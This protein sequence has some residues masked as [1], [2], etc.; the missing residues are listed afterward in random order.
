MIFMI[1]ST[2]LVVELGIVMLVLLGWQFAVA[3]FVGGPVMIVLLALVG[4]TVFSAPLVL[5]ARARLRDRSDDVGDEEMA[6]SPDHSPRTLTGWSNASSYALAD[7]TMLRTRT[8]HWL[9]GGGLPRGDGAHLV[10]GRRV[11]ARPRRL[12]HSRECL[13]G[14]T[15]RRRQLG[16]LGGQ[17]A[18]RR[19]PMARRHL[20]RRGDRLRLRRPHRDAAHSHLP[21]VLRARTDHSLVLTFYAV[22]VVAGLV[23]EGLFQRSSEP[24]RP[25]GSCTWALNGHRGITRRILN[26][27]LPSLLALVVWSL[28][29]RR[30]RLGEA[31]GYA[32]DPVCRMQVRIA[33]APARVTIEGQTFY[34]CADRCRERFLAARD[35]DALPPATPSTAP[36][37][38]VTAITL[39]P[40]HEV[41][42]STTTVAVDYI[43]PICGMHVS[44]ESAAAQRRVGDEDIYFCA[45]GCATRFDEQRA[46]DYIDPICGMHVSPESA[47]AQR[48]VDD[49]DIYFCAVGCA[50]RF[51]E[52]RHTL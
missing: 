10:V 30:H 13:G 18:P 28:A 35:N 38:P 21:Q 37:S 4:T 1:S 20:L 32:I 52:Q 26:I 7:A 44:P 3:E 51:D 15:D 41:T 23:T 16:L 2:N 31:S 40:R 29:R 42:A 22:M 36:E 33:D 9:P 49:E 25:V 50:T 43:D 47:A 39:R 48:R 5:A 45:V 19:R 27:V 12:D 24:C 11:L 6:T 34:F 8:V 14:A 46:V 17:R